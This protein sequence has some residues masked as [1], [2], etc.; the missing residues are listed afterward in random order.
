M[1]PEKL[2]KLQNQVRIGG[3][4]TPRRK[5]FKS[6]GSKG[7]GDKNLEKV[8]K[9]LD[10]LPLSNIQEVNM[11]GDAGKVLHFADPKVFAGTDG[12]TF[13]ISGPSTD[14]EITELVPGILNQLGPESLASLRKLAETYQHLNPN[15]GKDGEDDIPDLVENFEKAA[16]DAEETPAEEAVTE[17]KV[18][19]SEA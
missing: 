13:V 16:I 8:V 9:T 15:A 6:T 11:F 5:V 10:V 19:K 17:E 3:K 4:G 1:N 14:K 12:A 7:L 2:A 18:E